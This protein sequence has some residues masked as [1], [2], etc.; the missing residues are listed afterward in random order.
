MADLSERVRALEDDMGILQTQRNDDMRMGLQT[1]RNEVEQLKT[2]IDLCTPS[3]YAI[4]RATL[5][6]TFIRLVFW[7]NV[8][9]HSLSFTEVRRLEGFLHHDRYHLQGRGFNDQEYTI[10]DGALRALE[11]RNDLDSRKSPLEPPTK[12]GK[13][14]FTE[15]QER[16]ETEVRKRQDHKADDEEIEAYIEAFCRGQTFA[17]VNLNDSGVSFRRLNLFPSVDIG[18]TA[19]TYKTILF[20]RNPAAHQIT[21]GQ[22]ASVINNALPGTDEEDPK[23]STLFEAV[24]GYPASQA[25]ARGE[26]DEKL[27]N[28]GSDLSSDCPTI[29]L[30]FPLYRLVS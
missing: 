25:E 30:G 8:T 29:I 26:L 18:L 13:K 17:P 16:Y 22:I 6:K 27:Y 5:L 7:E 3:L 19:E 15:H 14:Y 1:L 10:E 11:K 24:L 4:C 9:K 28:D 23:L 12:K 20:A 21:V 2:R